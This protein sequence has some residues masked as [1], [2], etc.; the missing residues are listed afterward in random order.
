MLNLFP[1]NFKLAYKLEQRTWNHC[2][3]CIAL[4]YVAKNTDCYQE[5]FICSNQSLPTGPVFQPLWE[6]HHWTQTER[7]GQPRHV[8]LHLFSLS[9]VIFASWLHRASPPFSPFHYFLFESTVSGMHKPR[10]VQFI[11]D[12]MSYCNHQYRSELCSSYFQ[13]HI[14]PP[15]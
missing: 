6:D 14:A 3:D 8:P 2:H 7:L 11:M 5:K 1:I 15:T 13:Q 9:Y 12:C 10:W 4:R